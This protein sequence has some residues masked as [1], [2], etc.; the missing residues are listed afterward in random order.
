M[1]QISGATVVARA[2]RSLGVDTIFFLPGGP[3]QGT[4]VESSRLGVKLIGVRHEQ[5]AAMMAHAYSRATGKVG[6]C[7]T[8]PGPATVNMATGM[9]VAHDDCAPVLALSGSVAREARETGSFEEM[10]QVE[11]M[12]PISKRAWQVPTT[13]RIPDFVAMAFRHA[14]VNRPGPVYLDLPSDILLA[15]VEESQVNLPTL[16]GNIGRPSPDK[17]LVSEAIRILERSERPI[18]IAGS[19]ALW[20]DAGPELQKFVEYSQIPFFTTPLARGLV[21]EDHPLCFLGA[22]SFAWEAADAVLLI[23]SRTNFI[24]QHLRPPRFSKDI[25]LIAVNIDAEEIG[26]NRP[27]DIGIVG[28][29]KTVLHEFAEQARARFAGKP[30]S[31]S[32]WVER[33]FKA[34][35]EREEKLALLLD[36]GAKPIHPLRLCREIR[37]FLPRD[38]ILV[39]DGHEI[40]NFA[41]QSI[42]TYYPRHRLNP[43]PSGCMGVGVPFG[44][45]AKLARPDKPVLVLSGDGAFGVN[46]ME[47]DTAVRHKIQIVVVVSNNGGWAGLPSPWPLGRDLGFTRYDKVVEALGGW[48]CH[49]EDPEDIGPALVSAFASGKPALINVVTAPVKATTQPFGSAAFGAVI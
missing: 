29:A 10:D 1:S 48:G 7:I 40:L 26:H 32:A 41:R 45:A 23:G 37:D 20:A 49:V 43:G 16:P 21:P 46:A 28:D 33:L 9:A 2:L 30:R 27:V 6:V 24:I 42:R 17:G 18:V 13:E 25:K 3:T 31:T 22:R 39:V 14:T 5:A 11:L 15:Y 19:G 12:R 4:L 34:N 36:S 35:A 44:I 47:M 8:A 38:A